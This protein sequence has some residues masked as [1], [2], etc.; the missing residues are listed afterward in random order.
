MK[1]DRRQFGLGLTTALIQPR[2]HSQSSRAKIRWHSRRASRR[3]PATIFLQKSNIR[4]RISNQPGPRL[5]IRRKRRQS[6]PHIQQIENDNSESAYVHSKM[7]ATKPAPK[8]KNPLAMAI[9]KAPGKPI[10]GRRIITTARIFVDASKDPSRFLPTW[11]LLYDCWMKSLPLFDPPISPKKF[12]TKAQ[13]C[14]D[15]SFEGKAPRK[16]AHY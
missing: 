10:C 11:E 6:P 3:R 16:N 9:E 14:T 13:S 1:T 4:I 15:S 12:P 5:P 2:R 8:P 7:P